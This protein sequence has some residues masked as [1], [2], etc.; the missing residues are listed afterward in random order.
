MDFDLV[1]RNGTIVDGSGSPGYRGDVGVV[2]DRIAALGTVDGRGRQEI[3]AEGRIVSPGFVDGHTHMDAQVFW[4]ELGTNSCWHGITSV[5]MGNCGFTLAPASFEA[6]GLA[7]AN[8]ERAEDIARSALDA[9][10]EWS[11]TTFPEYLDAVDRVPK[12]LNNAA[13]VGHSAVRTWAMGEEAFEREATPDEVAKMV[14]QVRDSIRAGAVGFSTSRSPAHETPDDRPVASRVASWKE[15]QALVGVLGE[16]RSG[17]FQL[18]SEPAVASHDPDVRKEYAER[19][20]ALALDTGVPIAF[21]LFGTERGREQL[22]LIDDTIAHG[23]RMFG[24]THC[25]G[26][27]SVMSFLTRLPF[28]KLP[29]WSEL[30]ARPHNEQ[31]AAIQNPDVRTRLVLEAQHGAYGRAIGAEARRPD[32]ERMEVMRS[33]YLP[34]QSVAAESRARGVDPVELIIDLAIETNLKQLFVQPLVWQ[35]DAIMVPMLRHPATAMTFSDSGAHV[36]QI[37][38][39]SIQTFL[40]SSLVRERQVFTLEEAVNMITLRPAAHWHLADRGLLREG[41]AADIN[42]FDA[43]KIGPE[44]PVVADDLPG[45]SRRYVQ[46]ATG[47]DATIVNGSVLLRNGEETGER[48]GRLLRNRSAA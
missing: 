39:C 36:S 28:D 43:D 11:W 22:D 16:E 14:A 13:N 40:L 46:K 31:L 8:L 5:V 15:V 9:G 27:G 25:R 6:R 10:I 3:D 18:A 34:N 20:K 41:M 12:G 38:D 30:R 1:V 21:G 23:G 33:A 24:L 2:G 45:G 7:V 42:I 17:V 26:I 19:M 44:L 4:D 35:D 48:P 32:Y 29:A 37:V 47:F